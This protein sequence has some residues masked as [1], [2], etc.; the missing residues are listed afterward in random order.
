[1]RVQLRFGGLS[2]NL[3]PR[4]RSQAQLHQLLDNRTTSSHRLCPL[5]ELL[6][7]PLQSELKFHHVALPSIV[8]VNLKVFSGQLGISALESGRLGRFAFWDLLAK[9]VG[10]GC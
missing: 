2:A 7:V 10:L 6:S 4:S 8:K 5:F 3:E 9:F 1:M